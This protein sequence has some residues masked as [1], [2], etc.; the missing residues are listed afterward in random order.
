MGDGDSRDHSDTLEARE[1]G[2]WK[3]KLHAQAVGLGEAASEVLEG[4]GEGLPA[5][6]RAGVHLAVAGC[7]KSPS[8]LC[9]NSD[10]LGGKP[11][12]PRS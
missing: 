9:K 10:E 1:C 4:E 6:P 3:G 2:V 7:V 12:R 8:V 11:A 5:R